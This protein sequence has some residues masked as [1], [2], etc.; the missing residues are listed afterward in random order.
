MFSY[1]NDIEWLRKLSPAN[2]SL[3]SLLG[4]ENTGNSVPGSPYLDR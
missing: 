3:F 2:P 1:I 4:R